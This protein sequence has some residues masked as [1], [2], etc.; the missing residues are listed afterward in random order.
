LDES[1]PSPWKYGWN[2]HANIFF[3]DQPVGVGF[4]Y[5]DHGEYLVRTS[6]ARKLSARDSCLFQTTTEEAAIDAAAFSFVFFEHFSELKGN[7]FH[8]SGESYAG[9]YIPLFASAVYD[10]NPRLV[11]AGLDAVNLSSIMIGA[12]GELDVCAEI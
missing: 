9:R 10:L 6:L 4:S 7:A 5:A 2:E 8:M 12:R 11:K 3:I 1:G